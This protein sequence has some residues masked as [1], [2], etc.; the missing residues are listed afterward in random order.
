MISTY[1]GKRIFGQDGPYY[2]RNCST[3]QTICKKLTIL[4]LIN[5]IL[6]NTIYVS[7]KI[8]SF[9]VKIFVIVNNPQITKAQLDIITKSKILYNLRLSMLVGIS[10]AIRLLLT[11][12]N[13]SNNRKNYSSKSGSAS[14]E[15][16]FYE[17]LAGLIDGDGCFQL[18]K[19]GYASLE[20]VMD[21]RDKHCLYI[22]KQKYGGS[23][24]LRSGVNH[25]RYRL[26]HKAGL[27]A[28][29]KDVNGLIRNPTRMVQLNKI[30]EKYNII[31]KYPGPLT[32]NNGWL[33]GFVDSDGSI[34]LNIK[35]DQMFITAS[36]KNKLLLDPLIELYGGKIYITNKQTE[37][38]KWTVYR[39]E[40]ILKLLEYFTKNPLRS[41]KK[42]R[43]KMIERYYELRKLKA[44]KASENSI[45]GK[46][47]KTFINKWNSY[48]D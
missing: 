32:Y 25:L 16:F 35:S 4:K 15:N 7:N 13:Y 40:E 20:I 27:L 2:S 31:L 39:K 6:Q 5:M 28:L 45:L 47:W 37:A 3:Q 21:I 23:V 42:N 12:K 33:A 43:L 29:I 36:Q 48:E 19:K 34:Y 9:I 30:C 17:W 8:Y 24:K 26:H 10:E 11:K 18:T 46:L 38:F 22:I 41:A 1:S 44:H 14:E